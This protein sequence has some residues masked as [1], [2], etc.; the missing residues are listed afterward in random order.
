MELTFKGTE[1]EFRELYKNCD[2]LV[3]RAVCNKYCEYYNKNYSKLQE[4]SEILKIHIDKFLKENDSLI[5]LKSNA[6][7]TLIFET[8]I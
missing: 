5:P 6:S 2:M 7:D 8:T 3:E 4:C 1:E